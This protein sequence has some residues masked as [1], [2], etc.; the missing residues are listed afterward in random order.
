MT[1]K[2]K[3]S[4]IQS[5]KA[6]L[7][8]NGFEE[9]RYGNFIKSEKE[10]TRRVRYK[11]Q[12]TSLRK[13]VSMK[14]SPERIEEIKKMPYWSGNVE[15]TDWTGVWVAYYKDIEINSNGIQASKRIV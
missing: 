9:D 8:N 4:L 10:N 12:P 13:E 15:W 5:I 14:R 2:Q 1:K 11:F 3:L 7:F 6:F